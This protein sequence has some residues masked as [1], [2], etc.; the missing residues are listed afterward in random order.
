MDERRRGTTDPSAASAG[1]SR[2]GGRAPLSSAA[3]ARRLFPSFTKRGRDEEEG[4]VLKLTFWC[5]KLRY[6]A[7]VHPLTVAMTT[8]RFLSPSAQLRPEPKP[9]TMMLPWSVFCR[10]NCEIVWP[11]EPVRPELCFHTRSQTVR[12]QPD[13]QTVSTYEDTFHLSKQAK[14]RRKKRIQEQ[15]EASVQI[16]SDRHQSALRAA[17]P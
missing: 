5:S 11:E 3:D 13:L 7:K 12:I 8:G 14:R 17:R 4:Q 10:Q 2:W 15:E 16:Q 9:S 6:L 1:W